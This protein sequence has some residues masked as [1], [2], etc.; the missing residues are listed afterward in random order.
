MHTF[1]GHWVDFKAAVGDFRVTLDAISVIPVFQSPLR[2]FDSQKVALALAFLRFR[3]GLLL[4]G[5]HARQ[6]AD[7]LLVQHHRGPGL[8]GEF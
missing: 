8:F 1:F 5:I 6:A 7:G 4:H 2:H 3:H